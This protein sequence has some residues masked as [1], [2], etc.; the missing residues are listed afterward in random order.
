MLETTIRA[1]LSTSLGAAT[2]GVSV[3]RL[4]QG[5][6]LPWV[7]LNR[8]DTPRS[9]ALGPNNPVLHSK[10]RFQFDTWTLDSIGGEALMVLL[11]PAVCALP[12]AV[13]LV[14]QGG[15]Q[16]ADTGYWHGWLGAKVAHAGA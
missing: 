16:D 11:V 15:R 1:A 5:A 4:P 14:D 3:G 6:T 2:N 13:T 9:H 10:P 8:I 12:Y 7:T